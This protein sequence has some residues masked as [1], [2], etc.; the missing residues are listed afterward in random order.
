MSLPISYINP[1]G[2]NVDALHVK[3]IGSLFM[4]IN[5]NCLL[6]MR[7]KKEGYPERDGGSILGSRFVRGSV[8]W[9]QR[10]RKVG[11]PFS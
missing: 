2:I 11:V 6:L 8:V 5:Q 4:L 10:H 9:I 7:S 3:L 1:H